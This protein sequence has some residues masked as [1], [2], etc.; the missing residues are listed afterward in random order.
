MPAAG[1]S[2]AHLG[3]YVLFFSIPVSISGMQIGL[4]LAVAGMAWELLVEGKKFRRTPFDVPVLCFLAVTLLSAVLS[5]EPLRGLRQFAGSWT[6]A[7]LYLMARYGGDEL[8]L[9]RLL[10]VLF[11]PALIVA[12]YGIFQHLTGIDVLRPHS[13][14]A[15]LPFAGTTV[16]FPRG[17]FNHYQTFS[18]VFFLLFSLSLALSLHDAGGKD[19]LLWRAGL[20]L[21]SV[22]MV[23]TFTR[24]IWLASLLSLIIV[25]F[26]S[27][28]LRKAT[29]LL[30]AAGAVVAVA[31]FAAG[32]GI[33]A[34]ARSIFVMDQNVERLMLW[35]TTW[36]MIRDNPRLGV[37]VGNYQRV[38]EGYDR[39]AVAMEMT[40]SHSHNNLLQVTVERGLFGLFIFL[41]IWYLVVKKGFYSL[42]KLRREGGLTF[43]ITLGSLAGLLGFFADGIFQN[44]FGDTE[45]VIFFWLLVGIIAAAAG[46]EERGRS[47]GRMV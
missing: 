4:G 18:N 38:Q 23:L 5:G 22:A 21:M 8:L 42:W 9:R 41:W 1:R 45:V 29:V 13:P 32:P 10:K 2:G 12:A 36:N 17:T 7:G 31:L 11:W 16:F 43:G 33:S 27:F 26:L 19:R 14:L 40:R 24:G 35:E 46:E 28:S 47:F 6:V 30:V 20:V 37:G 3:L 39:P 34:R 44:N 15:S 25:A